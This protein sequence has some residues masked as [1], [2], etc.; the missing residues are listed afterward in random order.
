MKKTI[1]LLTMFIYSNLFAQL[2]IGVSLT[3]GITK[4]YNYTTNDEKV[5][6]SFKLSNVNKYMWGILVDFKVYDKLYLIVGTEHKPMYLNV[7]QDFKVEET[8]KNKFLVGGYSMGIKS[9]WGYWSFPVRISYKQPIYKGF[10]INPSVGVSYVYNLDLY[11]NL[12]CDINIQGI[13]STN[14]YSYSFC[15]KDFIN[16]NKHLFQLQVGAEIGYSHNFFSVYLGVNYSKGL[17]KMFLYKIETYEKDLYAN[18]P[19]K[20]YNV[21]VTSRGSNLNGYL[22][23]RFQLYP[24]IKLKKKEK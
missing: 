16:L 17:N 20:N 13:D 18:T 24:I 11:R 1:I 12:N 2:E 8:T 5:A 9:G 22:G 23:V 15:E 19:A 4:T 21:D 6:P 7:Y 14:I 10:Y 3:N